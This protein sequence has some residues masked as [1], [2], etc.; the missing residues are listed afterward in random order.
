MT[1]LKIIAFQLVP[2]DPVNYDK[3]KCEGRQR[4]KSGPKI[5]DP[6]KRHHTK[7]NFFHIN[8]TLA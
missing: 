4:V 1:V 5:S 3:S 2:E 8:G 7:L 6:S